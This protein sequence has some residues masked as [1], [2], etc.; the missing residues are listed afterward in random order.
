M[1]RYD[2]AI[3]G[4]GLNCRLRKEVEPTLYKVPAIPVLLTL[5]A[6]VL[7]PR[8][9]RKLVDE[10]RKN[11]R[12]LGLEPAPVGIGAA[13]VHGTAFGTAPTLHPEGFGEAIEVAADIPMSPEPRAPALGTLLRSRPGV[14][15]ADAH[16]IRQIDRQIK[17]QFATQAGLIWGSGV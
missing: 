16:D 9:F 6:I 7:L 13:S 4:E 10:A 11:S 5:A 15:L 12:D 2:N 1:R 3:I 14:E 17:Y 8:K